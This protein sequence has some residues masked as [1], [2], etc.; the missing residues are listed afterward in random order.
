MREF[1]RVENLKI[2]AG[3][4]PITAIDFL[5]VRE[6]EVVLV[7]G[8]S[9]SGKTSI[10]RC[11]AGLASLFGL[12][13]TGSI[14]IDPGPN[15]IAYIPQEPWFGLV[16]PYPILDIE[17][18]TRAREAEVYRYAEALGVRNVLE[19]NSMDLSAGEIQRV[20]FV[21]V[22]VD[23]PRLVLLDEVTAY[24]DEDSREAL[25]EAVERIRSEVGSSFIV[26]DHDIELWR[27]VADRVV[28]V[29]KGRRAELYE[30]IDSI[31]FMDRVRDAR[32][33]IEAIARELRNVSNDDPVLKVYNL[34]FKY[35]DSRRY[36]ISGLSLEVNRG[37]L[38]VIQ[39]ASGRGKSTLLKILIDIYRPSRG[40]VDRLYREAQY[41]PENPLLYLSEPTPREELQGDDALASKAMLLD[42][43]DTPITRLS[44]GERRRLAIAS[45]IKRSADIVVIDEPSVG[46]D[47]ENTLRVLR[48]MLSALKNGVS[49][50]IAT[51]SRLLASASSKVVRL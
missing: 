39:G 27:G 37:E 40:R 29:E 51:H 45:A 22:L 16:A 36:I 42:A 47:A 18:F 38:L 49:M 10:L 50:V 24:L 12:G 48:I 7:T 3:G 20:L 35:P 21:E 30:D 46:L 43:L 31:P 2:C 25:A 4:R 8:P 11:I 15:V 1:L 19:S 23:R 33:E 17:S 5:S 13:F 14:A 28:Y 6:G 9:G 32:R 44:S 34:W 26:V 41:I